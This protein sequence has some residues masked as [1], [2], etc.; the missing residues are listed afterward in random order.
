MSTYRIRRRRTALL[1]LAWLAFALAN[2]VAAFVL[3]M[4]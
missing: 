1:T 2:F 4:H 3:A